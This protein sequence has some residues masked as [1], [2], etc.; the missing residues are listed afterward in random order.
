MSTSSKA[1]GQVL[2]KIDAHMISKR[3]QL[4]GMFTPKT[5]GLHHSSTRFDSGLVRGYP[6][7][8]TMLNG[9]RRMCG[10]PIV[11]GRDSLGNKYYE[12]VKYGIEGIVH[13]IS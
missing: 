6:G 10:L 5:D 13:V 2:Q 1:Q 3:T 12:I 9:I 4:R 7:K 8:S 11:A